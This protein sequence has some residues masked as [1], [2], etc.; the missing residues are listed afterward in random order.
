[1]KLFYLFLI[2]ALLT[3]GAMVVVPFVVMGKYILYA[4]ALLVLIAIV[5]VM[6]YIWVL[7]PIKLLDKGMEMIRAKDF[8]STL[9][10]VNQYE[11][12]NVIKTFNLLSDMLRNERIR[13]QERNQLLSLLIEKSPT[14]IILLDYEGR[15]AEINPV[16]YNMLKLDGKNYLGKFLLDIDSKLAYKCAYIQSGCSETIRLSDTE[17]VRCSVNR[18]IDR[19][20]ER[21]FVILENLSDDVRQAER[22]AYHRVIR[23]LAHEVNNTMCGLTTTIDALDFALGDDTEIHDVLIGCHDR[24]DSLSDFITSFASVVKIPEPKFETADLN[25]IIM[26][27]I[28]FLES[29]VSPVSLTVSYSEQPAMAR[30]DSTLWEQVLVNIVKNSAESIGDTPGGNIAISVDN[31]PT[32]VT[33]TDN[34]CGISEYASSHLFSPFFSTKASGNGL[35]LILVGEVLRRHGCTFSLETSQKD[36]L[37]RFRITFPTV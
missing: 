24:C 33:I 14:G 22:E 12:D 30:I 29:I 8:S 18:F 34:G 10:S 11:A 15:I 4:E 13:R 32:S 36:D 9:K 2:L 21:N 7:R 25:K 19:G 23:M 5:E 35:G 37:T 31:Y 3:I 6:L 16:A 17:I 26:R 28:Q 20:F 27:Q 1:M